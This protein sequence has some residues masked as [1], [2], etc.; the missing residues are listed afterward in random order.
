[1]VGPANFSLHTPT[2]SPRGGPVASIGSALSDPVSGRIRV[3][4]TLGLHFALRRPSAIRTS[5]RVAGPR[6]ID[7]PQQP[8]DVEPGCAQHGVQRIADTALQPAPIHV[9][10]EFFASDRLVSK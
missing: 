3:N 2:I 5:K 1:M 8:A 7:R 9:A 10:V 4:V 6:G